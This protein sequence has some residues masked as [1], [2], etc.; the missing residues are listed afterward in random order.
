MK[1]LIIIGSSSPDI[2]KLIDS[3]NRIRNQYRILGY[4]ERDELT[5]G[6]LINGYKVIGTDELL[7]SKYKQCGVIVNVISTTEIRN[8]VIKRLKEKFLITDFPNIIHP[9][10]DLN[11]SEIGEGNIMYENTILG[12]NVKI[13]NFN[14][15]YYGS[16]LGHECTLG[17]CNLIAANALVGART[18]V[19][20]RVYVSN[21]STL[22]LGINICD[23]V[24]IGVGSVVINSIKRPKKVFGNP[25]KE[26]SF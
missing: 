23:D 9:S 12:A 10:I 8:S 16:I 7:L 26:L 21:S 19:G 22:N 3:I 11:Y 5:V 6:K 1:D 24:F 20:S 13:G 15:M 14:I 17:N 2:I 18:I 4:L 25:A